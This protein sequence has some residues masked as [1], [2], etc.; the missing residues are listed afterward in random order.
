MARHRIQ[1]GEEITKDWQQ[2]HAPAENTRA[3]CTQP[4]AGEGR[5]N[6]CTGF[7]VT[8][9]SG[10]SAPASGVALTARLIDGASGATVYLWE[11]TFAIQA[12]AGAM[13]GCVR[14]D[15]WIAGSPN[16]PMTLEWSATPG[17]GAIES[18]SMEGTTQIA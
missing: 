12:V 17:L 7:T 6:V 10:A 16:R 14:E 3:T 8:L 5:R 13:A 18:V 9:C 2:T 11:A 1:P 4:T 15:L